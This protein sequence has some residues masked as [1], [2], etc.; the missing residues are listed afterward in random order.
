MPNAVDDARVHLGEFA[1]GL[2]ADLDLA[3][4]LK[5]VHQQ[6]SLRD[7]GAH[8]EQAVVAQHEVVG[9][10]QVGLQARFFLVAQGYTFVAVVAQRGQYKGRL[11]ADG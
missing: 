5:V 2:R 8:G 3:S 1:A 10:A 6:E 11:L 7:G 4:G 9:T